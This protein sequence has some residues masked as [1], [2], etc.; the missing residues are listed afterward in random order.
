MKTI[1]NKDKLITMS[2]LPI[3]W[4]IYF[5]FEVFTGRVTDL[6][7]FILNFSLIFVFLFIGW[8]IFVLSERYPIG[9]TKIQILMVFIVLMLID[10]GCKLLIKKYF[11]TSYFEVIPGFLSFNPI[12]NTQ[13][14]WLNAR[15]NF[16]MSFTLLIIFN[17]ISLLLFIEI[18]RY[19]LSLGTKA[20]WSDLT[21]LFIFS[22]ALCSLIDKI[23]YG[24]SLDFIGISDLFIAD[25]KDIYINIGLLFFIMS[26]YKTGYLKEDDSTTIKD[27]WNSVKDFFKFI[28]SDILHLIKR[29]KA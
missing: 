15:F 25:I 1:S 24:G 4:L 18:Y 5:L 26:T 10:Q 17:S 8:I 28:R 12:I 9:F 13:G 29:E 2:I 23:F 11:F 16:N 20:Y 21:F 6:Y 7:T 19:V 27:D 22:G 14:S 3:M